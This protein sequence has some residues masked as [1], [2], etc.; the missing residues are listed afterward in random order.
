[1]GKYNAFKE[2]TVKLKLEPVLSFADPVFCTPVSKP[3]SF[4]VQG[5][6]NVDSKNYQ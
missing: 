6:S 4:G 1:M 5:A 3:P 2:R